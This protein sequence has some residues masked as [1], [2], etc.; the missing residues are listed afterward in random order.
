M[1]AVTGFS[2]PTAE[3]IMAMKNI[4]L[5]MALVPILLGVPGSAAGK[6]IRFKSEY[7]GSTVTRQD[8]N[9]DGIRS[10]LGILTCKSNLGRCTGQAVG[11][12]LPT[13]SGT[14]PNGNGGL[15]YTLLPGSGHGFTRFD[16]TG[17]M[18]FSEIVAETACYDLTTGILYKSGTSRVTGGTGRFAGA[19]GTGTFEGTQWLLYIDGDGNAFAAQS[20]TGTGTIVLPDR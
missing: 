20:G 14:C 19:T 15:T 9:N 17:D 13:G 8:S 10:A 16:K 5:G 1:L 2:P 3:E 12:A 6:E 11:E 18:I 4:L 7:S